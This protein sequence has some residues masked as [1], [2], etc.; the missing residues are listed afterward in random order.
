MKYKVGDRVV[1]KGGLKGTVISIKKPWVFSKIQNLKIKWDFGFLSDYKN[2][3]PLLK[4]VI[5]LR[6]E[7]S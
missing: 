1:F 6:A 7:L 2:N 5:T 3:D 4:K